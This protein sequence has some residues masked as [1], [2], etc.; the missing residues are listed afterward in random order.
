M[1]CQKEKKKKVRRASLA[2]DL[3]FLEITLLSY[4][5]MASATFFSTLNSGPPCFSH[6]GPLFVRSSLNI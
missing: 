1:A 6:T 5:K 4:T 3:F 2:G